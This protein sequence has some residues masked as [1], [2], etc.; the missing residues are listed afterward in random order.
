MACLRQ[1]G[2]WTRLLMVSTLLVVPLLVL[3]VVAS[4][5]ALALSCVEPAMALQGASRVFTGTITDTRDHR[6]EVAV[7]EV[8][9]GGPLAAT[10]WLDVG[11]ET[12]WE[13]AEGG[14]LPEGWS[15]EGT[16]VFAPDGNAANPCNTWRLDDEAQGAALLEHRPDRP[17]A[18]TRDGAALAAAPTWR[19]RLP[20]GWALA[21]LG[22]G[23]AVVVA[24]AVGGA[25]R[26]TR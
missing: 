4:S 9:R 18:P 17:L 15:P 8:W 10:V 1:M 23:L 26:R 6:I 21:G 16:W 2:M 24:G 13:A 19:D 3:P 7:E 12:W 14:D 22:A 20:S 11:L 5:P 25:R